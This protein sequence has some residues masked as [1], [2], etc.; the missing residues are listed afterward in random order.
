[1]LSKYIG[2]IAAVVLV[3]LGAF[4]SIANAQVRLEQDAQGEVNAAVAEALNLSLYHVQ[5]INISSGVSVDVATD[6]RVDFVLDGKPVQMLLSSHSVRSPDMMVY[7]VDQDGVRREVNAPPIRTYQGVLNGAEGARV[8]ASVSAAGQLKAWIQVQGEIWAL[9]PLSDVVSD[10]DSDLH[11]V[12]RIS[13]ILPSDWK[14]GTDETPFEHMLHG[15]SDVSNLNQFTQIAEIAFDADTEYYYQNGSSMSAT[16]SD[17]ES[18]MNAVELIYL[19]ES[20]IGYD[21]GRIIVRTGSDPYT[22]SNSS[23]LLSQFRGEWTTN[24]AGVRRDVAHL[25]T[26]KDLS[27]SVIG[28]AYLNGVCSFSSGYGVSQS[29]FTNNFAS[30]VALTAH[31]LGHNWSAN[32]CNGRSD[33]A[34]MCSSI[35]GCTGVLNRFGVSTENAISYWANSVGCLSN[36]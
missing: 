32:H 35:G 5:R 12:Y 2:E 16:I 34:I 15:T 29:K 26:G 11:V 20:G 36:I 17:I 13:D 18:I 7:A 24:Q 3:I 33:C 9:Q 28:I 6:V 25:M 1:M 10:L 21:I 22:T 8:A 14:C 23:S 27:G 30:R 4:S 31:E 19:N